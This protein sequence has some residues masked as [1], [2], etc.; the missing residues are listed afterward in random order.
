VAKHNGVVGHINWKV[1]STVRGEA[2]PTEGETV[3]FFVRNSPRYPGGLD[4]VIS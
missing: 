1:P 2:L 3:Q 4:I